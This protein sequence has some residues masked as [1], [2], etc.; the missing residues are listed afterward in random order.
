MKSHISIRTFSII[1]AIFFTLIGFISIYKMQNNEK[2]NISKIISS[3]LQSSILSLSFLLKQD[4]KKN[5]DINVIKSKLNNFAISNSIIKDI[6]VANQNNKI[7][8][9]KNET[10]FSPPKNLCEDLKDLNIYNL[11]RTKG[12]KQDVAVYRDGKKIDYEI[13]IIT[14]RQDIKKLVYSPIYNFFYFF[15]PLFAL[16]LLL[17]WL[18][19]EKII[20]LP[21]EKLRQF[22]YYHLQ[23]PKEF[24]IKELESIRY[25]L[26]VTFNRLEKE[27][28]ELY[29]LSTKDTLSGL[30]NR[31][32]LFDKLEY[33]IAKANREE[34][35][36]ALLFID[37]DNFKD[38]NDY[39]GHD[40]GDDILKHISSILLKS[41]RE[42]DFVSR[43]GGDEFVVVLSKF[44]N[45]IKIVEIAQ[46]I[47]ENISKPI[48]KSSEVFYV[49]AS[50]GIVLYPK[51]GEN[52]TELIKNADIAMYKAKELGK[53]QFHFF[54]EAL[55][56]NIQQK[57]SMQNA[58]KDALKKGYFEL[59]YQPKVDIKKGKI[60]SCEALIRWNDFEKGV[61]APD[62][63]IPLAEENGFIVKLGE[64]VLN[65]GAR[66]I[67]KW[68][69]TEL[70]NLKV[71]LNVSAYQF[72][73]FK[74]FDK[75][76][77]AVKD[78]DVSK[79][80]LE[81][82]ESAFLKDTKK[83]IEIIKK[84]KELGVSWSLDDFGTGYSSLS[85]LREI[86]IDTLKIDKSFIDAHDEENGK[87]F[88]S[89]IVNM[90]KILNLNVV[91]EGVETKN[92]FN[93]LKEIGCD[94]FQG[95]LCSKPLSVEEFEIFFKEY[96][97]GDSED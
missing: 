58:M 2:E 42:N 17:V 44:E 3:D 69:D 46:R 28:K 16:L 8:Y 91:A 59:Y 22:A 30:Y 10:T 72:Y 88:I 65:E 87:S 49:S 36:F 39:M 7:I 34:R 48:E 68:Q 74:F 90:G 23:E 50:I 85:Y 64:W 96:N 55:H 37:L 47:I 18:Y 80:D 14:D 66:Q 89:L 38:I 73:D 21:L 82:T 26:G 62:S 60:V 79:F 31:L 13:Y 9:P 19:L 94:K 6:Y 57:I 33:L 1:F 75:I 70:T 52:V 5:K 71:S 86:P 61:I 41:V 27:Q 35:E 12:C 24:L 81:I 84:I 76:K 93:F 15:V 43:I 32:S 25:S 29:S 56:E 78:I 63:F 4:L 54:T 51:N 53:N 95:Y 11:L 83:N 92:Q 77:Q 97:K 40:V 20:I 45:N 67:K